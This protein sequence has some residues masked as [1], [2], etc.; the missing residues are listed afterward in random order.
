MWAI[1]E[2]LHLALMTV[3]ISLENCSI[4]YLQSL[5]RGLFPSTGAQAVLDEPKQFR[6]PRSP[7]KKTKNGFCF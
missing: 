6:L 2:S 7:L 1:D 4:T 3:A 5:Q